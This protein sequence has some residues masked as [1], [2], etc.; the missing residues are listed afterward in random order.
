[1]LRRH[2]E[3]I[4]VPRIHRERSYRKILLS[5][6]DE[7]EIGFHRYGHKLEKDGCGC[8]GWSW[9]RWGWDGL[10]RTDPHDVVVEDH[11][12]EKEGDD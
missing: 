5:V 2:L 1:M 10:R 6:M 3:F 7:S 11:H 12:I 8:V 9:I 4:L